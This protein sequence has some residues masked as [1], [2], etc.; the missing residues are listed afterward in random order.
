MS[1]PALVLLEKNL[2]LWDRIS[3]RHIQ[4][5]IQSLNSSKIVYAVLVRSVFGAALVLVETNLTFCDRKYFDVAGTNIDPKLED[6]QD[7]QCV[8]TQNHVC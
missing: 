2:A 1:A 5:L 3:W 4:R 6:M 7:R 8:I